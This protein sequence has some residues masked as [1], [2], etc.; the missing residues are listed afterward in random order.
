[1]TWTISKL[2]ARCGL[3]RGT[4]L[5]Y[6]SIGL[7]KPPGRTAGN[8]RRY[9]QRDLERLQQICAY[10]HAGLTLE[11][12]RAIITQ[13]DR[14]ESDAAAVLKR[15]L[16]ALDAEIE[17]RRAHQRAILQLLKNDSIGRNKM[18]TKEKWV[19]IMK[20]SGM[21]EDAM[22]RWHAEF[23]KA[24]PAEH[25]EFLEYLH[26]PA[27]EIGTIRAWSKEHQPPVSAES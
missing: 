19:S 24:A 26:I 17:T 21:T 3:S 18:I 16:V 13:P 12:I 22:H 8:Y 23:E 10:R 2:A 27:A 25:Q 4:L 9:G 5:Y 20:A 11:D 1:M 15:R 7:L 6:E 14:R